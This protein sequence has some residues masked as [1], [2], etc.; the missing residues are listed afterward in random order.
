MDN[1]IPTISPQLIK[2]LRENRRD[3]QDK[4]PEAS[5]S[6]DQ[7]QRAIGANEV[8]QY[9]EELLDRQMGTFNDE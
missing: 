9:L 1:Y 2:H 8:L 5:W 7:I 4:V 3:W 6:I